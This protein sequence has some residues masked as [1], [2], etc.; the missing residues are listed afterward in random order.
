MRIHLVARN[1]TDSVTYGFLPAAA[2]LGAEVLL[3]TDDPAAHARAYEGLACPPAAVL[4]AQVT[5]GPELVAALSRLPRP[6]A[7][8]SNSDHL[9]AAAALAAGYLDLPAKPWAAALRC[10][11][12]ALMRRH[13]R[14]A[15]L[16]DVYALELGP[17]ADLPTDL[18]LPGPCVVKPR[19]GVASEEVFAVTDVT[20]LR[21]RTGEIRSRRPGA[22]LVVEEYLAGPL[23]TLETLGDGRTVRVLGGFTTRLG[24]LPRFVE[25]GLDWEPDP[26]PG[27]SAQVLAQ[28]TALGV[29]L[30]ACHTEYV[31]Q[32]GRARLV[33]VNYRLIGDQCDLLLA[34][35]LGRDDTGADLFGLVLG[36]HLGEAVVGRPPLAPAYGHARVEYVC[37]QAPGVLVA[38]PPALDLD[39]QKT[40]LCYRPLRRTGQEV[41]PT[42]TNRDY[43]GVVRALGDDRPAVDR[44]VEDF[45][46]AHTWRVLP[47]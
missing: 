31:V 36:A 3:V 45:L 23:R 13:I 21:A 1:P 24:P 12:K 46:A 20:E 38:A 25:V 14:A 8:V 7:V 2:R 30:G 5:S 39:D 4:G 35:L 22:A 27:I 17:G 15:G 40:R 19:E 18:R 10:K 28:L 29:G 26:G 44:A 43:L 42:G 34:E 33:E 47:R 41:A 16:D 11:N 6:D 37:A 9:Q 32:D